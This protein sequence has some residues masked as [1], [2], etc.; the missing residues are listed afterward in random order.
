MDTFIHVVKK[1]FGSLRG[2]LEDLLALLW[3]WCEEG[4]IWS[5]RNYVR[6]A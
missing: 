3:G 4:S 5:S 1:G 6:E 2:A